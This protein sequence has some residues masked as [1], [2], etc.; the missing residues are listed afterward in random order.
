M[1]S[2][3]H[4]A[5][6]RHNEELNG[7]WVSWACEALPALSRSAVRGPRVWV[8]PGQDMAVGSQQKWVVPLLGNTALQKPHPHLCCGSW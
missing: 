1:N 5:Q 3:S 8:D 7:I 4:L 2:Q 6:V